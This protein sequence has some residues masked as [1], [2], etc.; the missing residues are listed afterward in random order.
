M[1]A[2]ARGARRRDCI[3][4]REC[5]ALGQEPGEELIYCTVQYCIRRPTSVCSLREPHPLDVVTAL[6]QGT[7]APRIVRG[8]RES[9]YVVLGRGQAGQRGWCCQQG[10]LAARAPRRWNWCVM[11]M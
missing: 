8:R 11:D 6:E 10:R 1:P 5:A 4:C 2:D 9:A 3:L 7:I